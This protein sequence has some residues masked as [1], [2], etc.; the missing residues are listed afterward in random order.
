MINMILKYFIKGFL[1]GFMSGI[2]FFKNFLFSDEIWFM[3]NRVQRTFIMLLM[4]NYITSS[5]LK[6]SLL[7][8]RVSEEDSLKDASYLCL[9]GIIVHIQILNC[10][11]FRVS[12]EDSLEKMP[13]IYVYLAIY[14]DQIY[15]PFKKSDIFIRLKVKF[16]IWVVS[17]ILKRNDDIIVYVLLDKITRMIR[18]VTQESEQLCFLW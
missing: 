5:Y 7:Q 9:F 8:F 6:L 15:R 12:E 17:E 2:T 11:Q 10:G 3:S 16:V 18:G 4:G 1:K 14:D 13:L